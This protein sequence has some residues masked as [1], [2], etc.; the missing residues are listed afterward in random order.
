MRQRPRLGKSLN[1]I[2]MTLAVLV[3]LTSSFDIC[4]VIQ[5]GGN[6][7]FCQLLVPFLLA[8][9]L[10]HCRVG[11]RIPTLGTGA[12]TIWLMILTFFIP[13]PEFWPK[14]F[15]YCLWLALSVALMFSFVQL[16][17]EN[18][19]SLDALV[20]WYAYSFAFIALF[21][22]VQF[23]LPL[24]GYDSPFVTEWWIRGQ[25]PRANGF[26]YEPSYFAT[27]LLIGFVFVRSLRHARSNLL[28]ARLLSVICWST[29]VAI[30]LSSSR[31]GI[32]FLFVDVLSYQIV[33]WV[34]LCK[35]LLRMRLVPRTMRAVIPS[36]VSIG[37]FGGILMIAAEAMRSNPTLVLMFLNGTGVSDTAAHSVVQR[38]NAFM[39]TLTVFARQPF[40]GQ[41]LGGV[42]SAIAMLHGATVHSFE[43]SKPFEGMSVFAEVLAASGIVGIIPFL[44]FLVVTVRRPL[45][46]AN[47][48]GA[49]YAVLLRALVRSL[50]F[51][52]A[53]LQFN[54]NILR[55]YVWVHLAILAAVYAATPDPSRRPRYSNCPAIDGP[56][57]HIAY[58]LLV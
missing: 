53:I 22:I 51:A 41:S 56:K 37:I 58:L 48:A 9:A 57:D 1:R 15:G 47:F 18:G 42:S 19:R 52:W 13:V 27:Y 20:R 8:L 6:Y 24:F 29:A 38:Q 28:P 25:L 11:G 4:L 3:M 36:M 31:M 26:S 32:L 55:P 50:L 23:S 33:P 49:H 35:D 12:L 40:I 21:G 7:R 46:L 2:A 10:L 5:A 17:A 39:D 16:F 43:D 34:R 45:K 44:W 54:Q 30:V 14:S